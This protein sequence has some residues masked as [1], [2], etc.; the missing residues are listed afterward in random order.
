VEHAGDGLGAGR[1]GRAAEEQGPDLLDTPVGVRLL[2]HE[3]CA[4]GDLGQSAAGR[5]AAEAPQAA[6]LL[7]K[8]VDARSEQR[9]TALVTNIDFEAW[10][11]YLGDPPLAMA[12]LDRIVDGAIILKIAGQSY[13]AHRAKPG[14]ADTPPPK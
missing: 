3:D 11:E 8:V 12:L 9:S 13:R 5:P 10:G 14:K 4:A 7:Y 6:S 1:Q 2:H